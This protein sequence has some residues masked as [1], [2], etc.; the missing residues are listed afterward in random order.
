MHDEFLSQRISVNSQKLCR[1]LL[2]VAALVHRPAK[3][4]T[5]GGR[6][7]HFVDRQPLDSF[8]VPHIA[9]DASH[10]QCAECVVD[11]DAG[12]KN[13]FDAFKLR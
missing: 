13:F 2:I 6:H 3:Q 12:R 7:D 9:L 1:G 8:K 5:L 4:G 10:H 11:A